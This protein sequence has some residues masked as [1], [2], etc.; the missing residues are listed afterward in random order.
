M[1]CPVLLFTLMWDKLFSKFFFFF[2]SLDV[3]LTSPAGALGIGGGEGDGVEVASVDG[4]LPF[5]DVGRQVGGE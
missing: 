4:P 2:N 1:H 5:W 3:Y